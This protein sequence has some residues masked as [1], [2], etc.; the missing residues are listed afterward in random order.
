MA[1]FTLDARDLSD[2][3]RGRGNWC[4]S[5]SQPAASSRAP[6][7]SVAVM[8][9][10][11]RAAPARAGRGGA[12]CDVRAPSFVPGQGRSEK[13]AVPAASLPRLP[14]L[15]AAADTGQSLAPRGL[16]HPWAA[17]AEAIGPPGRE[18][19]ALDAEEHLCRALSL[20]EDVPPTDDGLSRQRGLGP[21]AALASQ[22][23]RELGLCR[24]AHAYAASPH[25]R[26]KSPVVRVVALEAGALTSDRRALH[27]V[28]RHG[29]E[30]LHDLGD[31]ADNMSRPPQ[32]SFQL[33]DHSG[34]R[35]WMKFGRLFRRCVGRSVL[36][37]VDLVVGVSDGRR[38][39]VCL[40][41]SHLRAAPPIHF[42][43]HLPH[44]AR[45]H[46]L[47]A[48]RAGRGPVE[49]GDDVCAVR[50]DASARLGVAKLRRE[51]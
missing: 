40:N 31:G 6:G 38:V 29:G 50:R 7:P 39:D 34:R 28:G 26:S 37:G 4:E 9:R 1:I 51:G 19:A 45:I 43:T 21:F 41:F 20:R 46:A 23:G 30:H 27:T 17:R 48:Y 2:G 22:C 3:V 12:A 8:G 11:D 36:D 13:S 49:G 24:H 42:A 32:C 14:W 18:C 33:G 16:R 5:A 35:L 47:W 15:K 10:S 44:D 25:A